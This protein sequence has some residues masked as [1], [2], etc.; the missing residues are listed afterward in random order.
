MIELL[1]EPVTTYGFMRLG[2]LSAMVVGVV[3]SVLSCLLVVRHQAL[4]GD[5]ISHAVLLGVAVG[6]VVA[7]STGILWGALAAAILTGMAI[8]YIERNS[9]RVRLDAGGEAQDPRPQPRTPLRPGS[10]RG[11]AAAGCGGLKRRSG[12]TP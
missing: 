4:L 12:G 10:A 5:A 3:Y 8:T 9:P 11:G 7:G 6:Y 2:L 1:V